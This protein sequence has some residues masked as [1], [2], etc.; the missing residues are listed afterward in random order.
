MLDDLLGSATRA[1]VLE[2]LLA[3]PRHPIHLR[4]L[5][6]RCGTGS[7]GVQREIERL[8]RIGLARSDVDET[9]RRLVSVVPGHPLLE[10]LEQ[11]VSV[12]RAQAAAPSD[13]ARIH[14]R[15]RRRLPRIVAACRR[16]GVERAVLFG[17]ATDVAAPEGPNDLDVV[18]RLGGPVEGRAERYFTLRFELAEASGL[19]V[20]LVEEETLTNPYLVDELARTGVVVVEAA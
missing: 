1:R 12:S 18:V 9:G 7:S 20:D 10:A 6:R 3:S 16:A 2:T 13:E 11:L 19:S 8:E 15:L 14:P 4:E 17:S 5:I